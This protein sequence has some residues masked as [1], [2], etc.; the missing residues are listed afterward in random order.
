MMHCCSVSVPE[1]GGDN[2]EKYQGLEAGFRLHV[3]ATY[4]AVKV[5][6]KAAAGSSAR[7]SRVGCC[8]CVH[9]PSRRTS[10]CKMECTSCGCAGTCRQLSLQL[11]PRVH[12]S[13]VL[14]NCPRP[15]SLHPCLGHLFCYGLSRRQ[16]RSSSRTRESS[17]TSPAGWHS[18]PR[19]PPPWP[20]TSSPRRRRCGGLHS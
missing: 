14:S 18:R 3:S 2:A 19:P 9:V 11:P 20:P 8:Y 16:R 17:S 6:V 15:R 7:H 1:M 12:A 4:T 10:P 5:R 13:C